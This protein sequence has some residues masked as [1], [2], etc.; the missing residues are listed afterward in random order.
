MTVAKAITPG[1]IIKQTAKLVNEEIL[2]IN[3]DLSTA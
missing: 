3:I 1:A 2:L